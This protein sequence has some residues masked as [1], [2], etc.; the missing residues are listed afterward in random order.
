[1]M[2]IARSGPFVVVLNLVVDLDVLPK[3]VVAKDPPK[4]KKASK[5]APRKCSQCESAIV[6]KDFHATDGSVVTSPEADVPPSSGGDDI[7]QSPTTDESVATTEAAVPIVVNEDILQKPDTDDSVMTV[8]AHETDVPPVSD[9]AFKKDEEI[10]D[11]IFE[12]SDGKQIP[13]F[14]KDFSESSPV[15]KSIFDNCKDEICKVEVDFPSEIVERVIEFVTGKE[16]DSDAHM[17]S[18]LSFADKYSM[19]ILKAECHKFVSVEEMLEMLKKL[20]ADLSC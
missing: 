17:E 12:T 13:A 8:T 9:S 15:L 19:E 14:Q 18:L 4:K 5:K 20:Q 6:T 16:V 7:L 2:P 1:M 11:L 3:I 10:H